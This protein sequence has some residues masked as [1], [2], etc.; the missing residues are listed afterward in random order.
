MT[1]ESDNS[2]EEEAEEEASNEGDHRQVA[3]FVIKRSVGSVLENYLGAPRGPECR[4]L[5]LQIRRT[6]CER[7]K[8]YGHRR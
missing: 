4:S 8:P 7:G 1:T 6:N 2:P 5:N 3:T